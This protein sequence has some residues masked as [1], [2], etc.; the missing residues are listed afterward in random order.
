M[1]YVDRSRAKAP[2]VLSSSKAEKAFQDAKAFFERPL[3]SRLQEHP[4]FRDEIWKE[5]RPALKELFNGKCAYCESK[6]V[7]TEFGDVDMFR[8]KGGSLNLNKDFD[9]DH[10][11]WLVYEWFNLY[12]SCA[13]C[14]R[15][16]GSRFPVDGPRIKIP[17]GAQAKLGAPWYEKNLRAE[18]RALLLDPCAEGFDPDK[19]LLFDSETGEVAGLTTE[20]EVSIEIFAL[21]RLD[22]MAARKRSLE[23]TLLVLKTITV[24]T[25]DEVALEILKRTQDPSSEFVAAQKQTMRRWIYDQP[26]VEKFLTLRRMFDVEHYRPKVHSKDVRKIIGT[27][28]ARRKAQEERKTKR[29]SL[30]PQYITRIEIHNFRVVGDLVLDFP[31]PKEKNESSWMVLLGENGVGKSSVL[32]AVTLALMNKDYY[33]EAKLEAKKFLSV[34][35]SSGYIKVHMTGYSV[36]F[37][38]HFDKKRFTKP[39]DNQ[40]HTYLFGYG[41]TRLLPQLDHKPAVSKGVVR[42]ENLFNPFL[43]LINAKSWMLGLSGRPFGYSALA[44]KDLMVRKNEDRLFRRK[45]EIKLRLEDFGTCVPLEEL[46]DGYQSIVALTADILKV[47]LETWPTAEKSQGI[48]LIDEID[49]HLH[50]QWKIKIVKSLR[51]VFPRVQ[52][53]VTTHDPLCLLG[54][55]PGEVYVMHHDA[56]SEQVTAEQV[57]VPPGTTADQVLTGFWFG[58]ASTM[59]SE[60]LAMLDTYY[61]LMRGSRTP[62]KQTR[63]HHMETELR[64]RLGAFSDT[65]IDRVTQSV[66]AEVMT[67]GHLSWNLEK[68]LKARSE[69]KRKVIRKLKLRR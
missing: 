67:E 49:M 14:N 15:T 46:S 44:M 36:P 2:A 17:Q 38:V 63:L 9:A 51:R 33:S 39:N 35:R 12:L 31:P 11:W 40:L 19:H 6:I 30:N 22:L 50:P 20:G 34:G 60:T 61:K 56:D 13:N 27:S 43:P 23:N 62:K 68:R 59:D 45:G 18:E 54:T 53:I 5:A 21:N 24:G 3:N 8:P 57:D 69:I 52:F 25:M 65:S 47:M 55:R 37:E 64:S 16:K 48:V 66:A 41:G 28:A 26:D 32:K 1:I 29:A 10:Y 58:L 42:A 7:A 4:R